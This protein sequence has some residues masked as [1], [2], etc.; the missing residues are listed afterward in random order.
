MEGGVGLMVGRGGAGDDE[1][2]GCWWEG[3]LLTV[4]RVGLLGVRSVAAGNVEGQG[5]WWEEY[6]CW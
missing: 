4:R 1:G 3:D 6:G 2:Q 5:C